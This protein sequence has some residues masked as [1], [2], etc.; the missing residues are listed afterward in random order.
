MMGSPASGK[1]LKS[2][3]ELPGSAKGFGPGT[4]GGGSANADSGPLGCLA[5]EDMFGYCST[6]NDKAS[7]RSTC[8]ASI[9]KTRNWHLK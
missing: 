9:T 6:A 3:S 8:R 2:P 4:A 1:P 7:Y 5:T